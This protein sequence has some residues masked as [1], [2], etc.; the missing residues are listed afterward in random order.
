MN[1]QPPDA[2]ACAGHL[3]VRPD[4]SGLALARRRIR[5]AASSLGF[6]EDDVADLVIAVGEAVSNAYS[7][8]RPNT[9][10]GFIYI[11]WTFALCTLTV[12]IRD[13]RGYTD[14]Q[15]TAGAPRTK[16]IGQGIRLMQYSV[17]EVG[18]DL[19][20]GGRVTLRKRSSSAFPGC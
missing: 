9:S 12:V 13:D 17:D 20:G 1:D 16:G 14:A 4:P 7:H 3:I 19:V 11:D 2:L 6:G 10:D 8:G 5:T 18:V 15:T